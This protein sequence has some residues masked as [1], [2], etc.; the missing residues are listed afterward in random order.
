MNGAT[1]LDFRRKDDLSQYPSPEVLPGSGH[2]NKS[3]GHH[4]KRLIL[5]KQSGGD[6]GTDIWVELRQVTKD[7]GSMGFSHQAC[8]PGNI[9]G[10]RKPLE[11]QQVVKLSAD[12]MVLPI[13]KIVSV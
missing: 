8:D 12:S 1:Q 7:P 10:A 3:M 11:S 13:Q 9:A 2:P 6:V 4:I 5:P